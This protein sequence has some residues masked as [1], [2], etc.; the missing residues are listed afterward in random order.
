VD[1]IEGGGG[2]VFIDDFAAMKVSCETI[3]DDERGGRKE[4]SGEDFSGGEKM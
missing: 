1:G 3:L 4:S 2:E